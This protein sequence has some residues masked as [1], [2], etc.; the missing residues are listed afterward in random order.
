MHLDVV[1]SQHHGVTPLTERSDKHRKS[2]SHTQPRSVLFSAHRK[3][4]VTVHCPSHWSKNV[5]LD[6][7]FRVVICR[8]GLAVDLFWQGETVLDWKLSYGCLV[9]CG[10]SRCLWWYSQS[11]RHS[12]RRFDR[13]IYTKRTCI[14]NFYIKPGNRFDRLQE[15]SAT[16]RFFF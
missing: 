5:M 14:I 1:C 4:V 16:K 6:E 11:Q 3:V 13:S 9:L 7:T 10:M 12:C 2:F 15:S 8:N